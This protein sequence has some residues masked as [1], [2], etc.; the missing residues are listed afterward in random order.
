[1]FADELLCSEATMAEEA[2]K[3]LLQEAGVT[4][5]VETRVAG[6]GVAAAGAEAPTT[7]ADLR[8]TGETLAEV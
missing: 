2:M 5:V 4:G 8:T 7:G 3:V 1:M 6:E